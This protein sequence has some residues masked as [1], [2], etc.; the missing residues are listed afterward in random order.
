MKFG[1]HLLVLLASIC[2]IGAR[3]PAASAQPRDP[4]GIAEVNALP[5]LSVVASDPRLRLV[6]HEAVPVIRSDGG[7]QPCLFCSSKGTLFCQAQ[8]DLPPFRTKNKMVYNRRIGSAVS[9]DGGASWTRW[10]H[11]EGHDDVFIEGGMAECRDGTI[12]L[13]DTYV[14]PGSKADHGV[15]ELW[16]SHDDLR[17]VDGPISVDFYLPKFNW[18]GSSDDTGRPHGAARLHRSIIEMPNGD[19]LTTLYGWF[20]DD[21]APC[22]YMPTMMKTRTVLIRSTDRG[23]NWSYLSTVAVDGAVGTE[24]FGEPV[25]VRISQGAHA[26]RLL[27][28]MRTGRE[29]YGAHSDDAGLSWSHAEPVRFPGIVDIYATQVWAARFVD[30]DAPG[31]MPSDR[32]YGAAVDP[33][34]IEMDNGTLVCTVGVRIPEKLCFKDWR[35][36]QNGDYLAFSCDGGDTSTHIVQFRS[37]KPTTHY[38]GVREVERGVL[39][40]AYD[41]SIWS[42]PAPGGTMGFRLDVVRTDLATAGR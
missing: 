35:V 29:L 11:Q 1:P 17:T 23:A 41:D 8:L 22:P 27:C 40:V 20:G 30:T 28:L 7:H 18:R 21:R 34:L 12:F 36:P 6:M 10:T 5:V 4:A 25:L 3:L 42:K 14:M 24:G 37:G 9:R 26:G 31:Y 33:D 15:G 2:P 13:L 39:F 16:K 38:M 19:L 32:M